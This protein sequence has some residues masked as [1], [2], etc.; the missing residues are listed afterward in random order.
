MP[1]AVVGNVFVDIKGFPDDNY[2]PGGRN[3]GK[4]EI[5][6]GGVGAQRGGR[7]SP[8]LSFARALSAWWTIRPRARRS[9]AS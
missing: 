7:I 1:I 3:A 9:C 2:I 8:I 5:V 4:V 6:H